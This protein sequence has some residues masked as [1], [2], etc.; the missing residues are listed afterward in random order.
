MSSQSETQSNPYEILSKE[1][2]RELRADKRR[3]FLFKLLTWTYIIVTTVAVF[4]LF[5]GYSRGNSKP[6]ADDPHVGVVDVFGAIQRKGGVAQIPQSKHSPTRLR[7]SRALALSWIWTPR[8]EAQC[9][10]T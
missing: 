5:Y 8:A 7:K 10:V 1:L 4:G 2:M 6:G 3:S 9:K